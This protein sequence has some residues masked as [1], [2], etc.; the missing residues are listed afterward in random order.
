[1]EQNRNFF[2]I[3]NG[4]NINIYDGELFS[5]SCKNGNY[6]ILKLLINNSRGVNFEKKLIDLLIEN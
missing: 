3:K 1:M 2:V 6:E 4:P 5:I